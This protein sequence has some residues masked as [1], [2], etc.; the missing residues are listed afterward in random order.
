M[1]FRSGSAVPAARGRYFYGDSCSGT[2]WSLK[3]RKGKAS[4]LRRERFSVVG[5][6]GYGLVSF[7]E[8]ARG[9]LYLVSW[10][11]TIYRLV[12]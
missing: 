12:R 1:L 10:G 3:L 11:G 2:V 5:D 8:G 7:G 4:G 6:S 9:E